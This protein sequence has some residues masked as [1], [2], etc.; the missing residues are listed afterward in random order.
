MKVTVCRAV[1]IETTYDVRGTAG[2]RSLDL[3]AI[4]GRGKGSVR[5]HAGTTQEA[6]DPSD[7]REG[8]REQEME[9]VEES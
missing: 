8:E 5:R 2:A 9:V 3:C 7:G 4:A 1:S 6:V